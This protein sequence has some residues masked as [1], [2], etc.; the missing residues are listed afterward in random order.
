MLVKFSSKKNTALFQIKGT[1]YIILP[2]VCLLS[3]FGKFEQPYRV[4]ETSEMIFFDFFKHFLEWYNCLQRFV[5][6]CL[7]LF[8][9]SYQRYDLNDP[10][11]IMH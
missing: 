6:F 4:Y 5:L 11:N 2:K 3:D 7:V 10:N 1:N 8:S 9:K